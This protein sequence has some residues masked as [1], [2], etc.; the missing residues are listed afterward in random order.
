[1]IRQLAHICVHSADLDKTLWFYTEV[2]GLDRAFEFERNGE[3]CGYYIR[4]GNRTFIEVFKGD[5]GEQGNIRHVAVEVE[6]MD[7]L[8]ERIKSYGVEVGDKRKGSDQ[9]WQVWVV[10]PNGIRIEFHEYTPQSRQ[11]V[12]GACSVNW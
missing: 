4:V 10:D 3:L 12:G 9:S 6:D 7:R 5:P 8:I 2:L 1:M 11:M